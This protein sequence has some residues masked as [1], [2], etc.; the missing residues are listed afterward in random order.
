MAE[1]VDDIGS[2][3]RRMYDLLDTPTQRA[4]ANA[5]G[6]AAKDEAFDAARPTLGGD[7]VMS[8]FKSGKVELKIF[9]TMGKSPG[10]VVLK[11][12]PAGLWKLADEGRKGT[13]PIYPRTKKATGGKPAGRTGSKAL[14]GRAVMTPQ[15]PRSQSRYTPSRGLGT[16]KRAAA[17]ERRSAPPAGFHELQR[18]IRFKMNRRAG[19]LLRR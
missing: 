11:H 17:A 10:T 12:G 14:G 7:M 3:A 16:F 5:A 4:V 9:D 13:A 1:R 2:Y 18:Q 6:R 15:G 19:A 8:R